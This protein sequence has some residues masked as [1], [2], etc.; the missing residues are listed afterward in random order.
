MRHSKLAG[1][2]RGARSRATAVVAAGLARHCSV[3][4]GST[5]GGTDTPWR[6]GCLDTEHHG[7]PLR[8]SETA[9][10]A[11][12]RGPDRVGINSPAANSAGS[13]S[14]GCREDK[15]GACRSVAPQIVAPQFWVVPAR[16][17]RCASA[18]RVFLNAVQAHRT[19]RQAHDFLSLNDR[20]F[21]AR[22]RPVTY[23]PLPQRPAVAPTRGDSWN[24]HNGVAAPAPAG[25]RCVNSGSRPPG[26]PNCLRSKTKT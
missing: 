15:N 24:I 9:A 16:R 21:R 12:W 8:R 3:D 1:E 7:V 25:Q 19:A 13:L 11:P 26:N 4:L 20:P 2:I 17:G 5:P 6:N 14:Q 10:T 23:C 18:Q 22:R